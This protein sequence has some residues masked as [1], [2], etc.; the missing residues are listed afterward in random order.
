VLVFNWLVRA[1]KAAAVS[2]A[3]TIVA[4]LATVVGVTG[5]PVQAQATSPAPQTG[6]VSPAY[7]IATEDSIEVQVVGNADLNALMVVLPDGTVN[8]PY[9]GRIVVA[10][11][12]VNEVE[13]IIRKALV[14]RYVN[15]Q[16]TVRVRDQK[17]RQVNVLGAVRTVGKLPMREGWRVLDAISAAGGLPT[18]RYEFYTATLYSPTTGTL[19]NLDLT[20][21]F[22]DADPAQNVLLNADDMINIQ[23][24]D[25]SKVSVQVLGEV[26]KAGPVEVP[27]NGSI[28]DVL[29]AAG[30]PTPRAALKRALIER[31]DSTIPVD[32]S[33]Y[34]KTGKEIAEK[35][36]AGDRLV[37][38]ANKLEY[39]VFGQVAKGGTQFF[40]EDRKLM[41]STALADAGGAV[42]GAEIKKTRVTRKKPDGTDYTQV[43]D[44]ER[45]LKK[46]DYSK[47]IEIQP[48]DTIFVPAS[49][50]RSLSIIE[51]VGGLSS[52][53]FIYQIIR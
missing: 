43:V 26:A 34:Q 42:Q 51:M 14:K 5:G 1:P 29:Q 28:I 16:V 25:V 24:L 39:Y 8:Y 46:G 49:G 22:K 7:R 20:K 11:K 33:D 35:V 53:V 23:S 52:L 12:T 6:T 50:K 31:N 15:P 41:L 17:L 40:P 32:L 2:A 3:L 21:L 4:C 45:M 36:Q 47:D 13:T 19:T 30:G 18:D 9:T 44:V 27:R 37:I 10:G 38:P 48:N